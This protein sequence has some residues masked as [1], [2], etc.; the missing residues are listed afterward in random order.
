M[1]NPFG[2]GRYTGAYTEPEYYYFESYEELEEFY[3]NYYGAAGEYDGS[4]LNPQNS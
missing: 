4:G 1:C 2:Y 3:N